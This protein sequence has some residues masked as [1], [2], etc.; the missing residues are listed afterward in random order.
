MSNHLEGR[1]GRKATY[2]LPLSLLARPRIGASGPG[3]NVEAETATI[4]VT[5]RSSVTKFGFSKTFLR[6]LW[7]LLELELSL[8]RL[9]GIVMIVT[10]AAW[11]RLG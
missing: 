2:P 1:E 8:L 10:V 9:R 3:S 11:S 5:R 7:L 6:R 4:R